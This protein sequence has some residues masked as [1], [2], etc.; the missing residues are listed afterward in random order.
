MVPAEAMVAVEGET[1]TVTAGGLFD[2]EAGLAVETPAQAERQRSAAANVIRIAHCGKS[3]RRE[4]QLFLA[5]GIA[6]CDIQPPLD[7]VSEDT[8]PLSIPR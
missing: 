4:R 7:W 6:G 5:G 2:D 1:V 8:Q 3:A